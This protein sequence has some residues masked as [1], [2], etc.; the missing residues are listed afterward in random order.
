V[1]V[2]DSRDGREVLIPFT[3]AICVEV[4]VAGRRVTID[5]PKGLLEL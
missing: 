2:V 3:D 4:N 5:P 1:L